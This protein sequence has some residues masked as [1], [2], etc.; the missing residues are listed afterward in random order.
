MPEAAAEIVCY[1]T[2]ISEL[3][4]N[5]EFQNIASTIRE[6]RKRVKISKCPYFR[7]MQ[8]SLFLKTANLPMLHHAEIIVVIANDD[9]D[10]IEARAI[11]IKLDQIRVVFSCFVI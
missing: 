4:C 8:S 6:G 5:N 1:S 3:Q 2:L 10:N 7:K 9:V 11:V